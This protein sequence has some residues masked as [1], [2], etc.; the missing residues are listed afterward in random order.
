MTRH[1]ECPLCAYGEALR[2]HGEAIVMACE[3]PCQANMLHELH[4]R[5]AVALAK[6]LLVEDYPTARIVKLKID[7]VRRRIAAE[8]EPVS[9]EHQ[10]LVAKAAMN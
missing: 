6:A 2:L 10:A 9:P 8:D 3:R 5:H 1:E 7:I 4:A